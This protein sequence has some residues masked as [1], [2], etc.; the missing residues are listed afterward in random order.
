MSSGGQRA[1][2]RLRTTERGRS[3]CTPRWR[4][5]RARRRW[6]PTASESTAGMA[7]SPVGPLVAMAVHDD[8]GRSVEDTAVVVAD[9]FGLGDRAGER[10]VRGG[11]N[12]DDVVVAVVERPTGGVEVLDPDRG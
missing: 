4:A 7:R 1:V 2:G 6:R 11:A 3:R 10:V 5:R 8:V 12:V 9:A